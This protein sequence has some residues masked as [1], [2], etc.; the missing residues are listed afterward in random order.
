MKATERRQFILDYLKKSSFVDVSYLKDALDVSEMTIRRDLARLEAEKHLVRVYGGARSIPFNKFEM[1]LHSRLLK[2]Q[3][4]KETIG[5]YAA[6]LVENNDV[7]AMDA[8]TTTYYMVKHLLDK[9][10]TAITNNISIAMGLSKSK[11]VE[12][13]LLGG[14]LKKSS[15]YLYG[16]DTIENM[17]KYNT[18]KAFISATSLDVSLGLTDINVDEGELKKAMIASAS[19]VYLLMDNSK[20]GTR[21]YHYVTSLDKLDNLITNKT[22]F[23]DIEK[24]IFKI[25]KKN[26][27]KLHI[28]D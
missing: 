27:I 16:Y 9:K 14:N 20:F 28:C 12:V 8:S 24:E 23:N 18:D 15:L 26:K 10:I 3:V 13:V 19:Q 21:S 25:C 6:G 5:K 7:I 1:P 4:D 11:T 22:N 2:N 17:K